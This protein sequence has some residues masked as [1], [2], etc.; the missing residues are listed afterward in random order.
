VNRVTENSITAQSSPRS[1]RECA[2]EL[3]SAGNTPESVASV[4]GMTV[5]GLRSLIEP[6]AHTAPVDTTAP[7]LAQPWYRFPG[8]A[9]YWCPDYAPAIVL[10]LLLALLVDVSWEL[11]FSP[12]HHPPRLATVLLGLLMLVLAVASVLS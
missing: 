3:I 5:E 8:N 7:A 10:V 1:N 4:F 11:V 2:M 12:H 9:V 6:S